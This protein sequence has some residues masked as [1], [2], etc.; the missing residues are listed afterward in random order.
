MSRKKPRSRDPHSWIKDTTKKAEES[1]P[2]ASAVT[3]EAAAT[4]EAPPAG[5]AAGEAPAAGTEAAAAAG[6]EEETAEDEGTATRFVVVEYDRDDGSI[7]A[8][9]E[10]LGETPGAA[11]KLQSSIPGGRAAVIPLSGKMG[12]KGLLDIHENH[13]VDTSKARPTLVPK[14]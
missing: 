4:G 5:D 11:G 8:T 13:R 9:H 3:G 1:A 12:D 14:G 10:L 2:A 7:L 6:Q